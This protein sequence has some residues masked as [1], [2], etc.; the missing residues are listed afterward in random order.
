MTTATASEVRFV[1]LGGAA[2][3]SSLSVRTLRRLIRS[4]RLTALRPSGKVLIDV[5]QL[6][7]LILESAAGPAGGASNSL[8]PSG[9]SGPM[10]RRRYTDE[11][12]STALVVLAAN[13][14]NIE[15][16][17][18]EL[19][20]PRTTL[21]RWDQGTAHPE[22]AANA[23]PKKEALANLLEGLVYDAL[24]VLPGNLASA[25]AR[26]LMTIAAVAVDKMLLL[27]GLPTQINQHDLSALSDDDLDRELAAAETALAQAAHRRALE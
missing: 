19:G 8:D 6:D 2:R 27:R 20:I 5:Q 4:G 16:T 12:R 9:Q 11:D 7:S 23:A 17:A 26:Q 3:R 13:G 22:A 10:A 25:N 24:G 1:S 15:R 18:R 21:Q 14:G